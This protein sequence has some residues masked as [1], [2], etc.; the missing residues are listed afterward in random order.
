[1]LARCQVGPNPLPNDEWCQFKGGYKVIQYMAAGRAAEASPVG[2][3]NR[4]VMGGEL[5]LFAANDDDWYQFMTRPRD[6]PVLR[7][8]YA[9]SD[10]RRAE[11]VFS[12]GAVGKT[13][14]SLMQ[15]A[16]QSKP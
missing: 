7:R 12:I 9:A 4:G 14:V 11:E 16:A 8:R 5:G 2:A 6:D 15:T 13:L 10:R 1:M 3:E